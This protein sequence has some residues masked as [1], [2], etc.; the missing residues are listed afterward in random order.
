M[1]Q[2][3]RKNVSGL[4]FPDLRPLLR[5]KVSSLSKTLPALA[6]A[7]EELVPEARLAIG[8]GQM[9]ERKLE[10]VMLRFVRGA[11]SKVD[12]TEENWGEGEEW[13]EEEWGEEEGAA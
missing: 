4:A 5:K 2:I 3:L 9:S 12:A 6:R 1:D 8:H 10:D 13:G 11:D 7:I